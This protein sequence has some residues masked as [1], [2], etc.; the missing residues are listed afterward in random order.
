MLGRP[1]SDFSF[2]GLKT[3][4][5]HKAAELTTSSDG[6][7]AEQDAADLAACFQNAVAEVLADRC[8]NALER[9][10]ADLERESKKRGQEAQLRSALERVDA[11]VRHTQRHRDGQS[12]GQNKGMLRRLL[13]R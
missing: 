1:G 7:L 10:Q 8:A 13:G 11:L 5:R 3:A 4:V 12:D 6:A 9:F 2:S